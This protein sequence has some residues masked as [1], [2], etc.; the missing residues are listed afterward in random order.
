MLKITVDYAGTNITSF[1]VVGHA[2]YAPL[3]EDICCAGVSAI[4]QTALIGLLNHL[5]EEPSY[6]IDKGNLSVSLADNLS[7][8]DNEKA[9]IILSTMLKG[10]ESMAES[11]A[12]F[13][14]VFIRR[15]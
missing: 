6:S 2:E 5:E 15:C 4:T 10:L 9:Q 3:G 1:Q 11:Y 8:T 12:D 7:Q 14:K 13:I